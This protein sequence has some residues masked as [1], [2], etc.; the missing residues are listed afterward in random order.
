MDAAQLDRAAVRGFVAALHA[1]GSSR[2]STAL[3]GLV[4]D[5]YFSGTKLSWLLEH[6]KDARARAEA[7]AWPPRTSRWHCR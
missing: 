6:V 3:T 2:A 5:P 4:L 7:P 1:R